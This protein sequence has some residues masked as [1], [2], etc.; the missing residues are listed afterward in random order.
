MH[1][2]EDRCHS[3]NTFALI[4]SSDGDWFMEM[5]TVFSAV[6]MKCNKKYTMKTHGIDIVD[7]IG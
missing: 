2:V 7:N 6:H 3:A 5:S 1:G 4:D